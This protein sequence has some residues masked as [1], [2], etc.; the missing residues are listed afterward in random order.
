MKKTLT[1]LGLLFASGSTMA[2][3]MECMVDTELQ[4]S[5]GVSHCFG[6]EYTM[7]QAPNNA[8]WR[9]TNTTK[10]ISSVIWSEKATGCASNSTFCTKSIRP[11]TFHVGKATILYTDGTYEIVQATAQFETGL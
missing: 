2:A 10:P 4:N 1:A 3:N 9:V 5:W 6:F 8:T 7:D 11:F